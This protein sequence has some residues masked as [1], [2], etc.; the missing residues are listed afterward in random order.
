[1]DS[2]PRVAFGGIPS[3]AVDEFFEQPPTPTTHRV[4][5][6]N[7]PFHAG[8]LAVV[9]VVSD[10]AVRLIRGRAWCGWLRRRSCVLFGLAD[11]NMI[12]YAATA[13]AVVVDIFR[14][15]S[16]HCAGGRDKRG[17]EQLREAARLKDKSEISHNKATICAYTYSSSNGRTVTPGSVG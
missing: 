1:M 13:A 11:M 8:P 6:G 7:K 17:D 10:A 12:R 9:G 16:Q 2:T 3:P 4:F 14:T 5:L 15:A